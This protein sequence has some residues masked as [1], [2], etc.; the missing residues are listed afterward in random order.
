MKKIKN[1]LPGEF[2]SPPCFMHEIDPVYSGVERSASSQQ[3]IDVC[4]WRKAERERQASMRRLLSPQQR[5]SLD[6]ISCSDKILFLIK[7]ILAITLFK[8]RRITYSH[9]GTQKSCQT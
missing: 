1:D 7:E 5:E 3:S 4:R 9:L 8:A 2:A 6:T